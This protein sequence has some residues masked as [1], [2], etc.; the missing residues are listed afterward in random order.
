MTETHKGFLS[1][2]DTLTFGNVNT[3]LND[4]AEPMV[5]WVGKSLNLE[6]KIAVK[7][8]INT[9]N[10]SGSLSDLSLHISYT[11]LYGEAK[12]VILKNPEVYNSAMSRYAF[13]FNGL[14]AAELR[15]V[16]SAQVYAGNT[17]VSVTMVYSP[18]TYGNNKTGALGDLCAALMAYSDSA[19][20]YFIGQ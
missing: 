3:T 1:N 14:L 10:Y 13:S 20:N 12:T 6:S 17:P 4:L 7:Y 11:D 8:I 15:T 16:L 5:N 19:K 18:D 2:T 9:A